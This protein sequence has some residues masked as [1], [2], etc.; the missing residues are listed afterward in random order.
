MT[1]TLH[2]KLSC[3]LECAVQ[4]LPD[5][6]VVA[7]QIRV[8]GGTCGEPEAKLGL[9]RIVTETLDKGTARHTGPELLD[10]FDSLGA[11]HRAGTGRET[12]TFT[13][14]VLPEHFEPAVALHAEMLRTPTFPADAF[15]VN[16]ELAR[17]ELLALQDDPQGLVDKYLNA[18]AFGPVL[19]RHALGERDTLDRLTRDDVVEFWQTHFQAGRMLVA[20]AG[21]IEPQHALA[22]LEEHFAGFGTAQQ[23]ARLPVAFG[24]GAETRHYPKDL[25]QEQLGLCWPGVAVTDP[26]FPVQQVTLGVLSG[27]MSA[28]LFT[29]V[30]EKQGLV[31]WVGAWQETPRGAGLIF[32]GASTRPERCDRTY[33]TL[34][35]EV[36]RLGKDLTEEELQRAITGLVAAQDTR[37]DTTRA[38]CAELGSDLFYYGHPVSREKKLAWVRVV[39]RADVERYLAGHPRD[40]LSV[41]TLGPRALGAD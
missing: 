21:A 17:Q 12:A 10:A 1:D 32:L 20:V 2:T 5:R 23:D 22:L 8:L 39:T 30:R 33:A 25:E 7:F 18:Q 6:H 31:Y 38:R 16:V 35:A 19:G 40:R 14:T 11:H 4:P 37:G 41:V 36:D 27:G 15:E 9:A 29:E 34:L 24:F 26:D 13:C 28:R 3:G